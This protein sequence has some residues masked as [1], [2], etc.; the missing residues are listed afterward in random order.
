MEPLVPGS[1]HNPSE[2]DNPSKRLKLDPLPPAPIPRCFRRETP[3]A[4]RKFD[5]VER[6]HAE[7]RWRHMHQRLPE[8]SPMSSRF[9]S[10]PPAEESDSPQEQ[11]PL[12]DTISS[13]PVTEPPRR[14]QLDFSSSI[15]PLSR[16]CNQIVEFEQSDADKFLESQ[17]LVNVDKD[18]GQM[19]PSMAAVGQSGVNDL[20]EDSPSEGGESQP[21]VDEDGEQSD[22][23][24]VAL[25]QSGANHMDEDSQSEGEECQI[26]GEESDGEVEG[27]QSEV[28]GGQ[29]EGED[30]IDQLHADNDGHSDGED[31]IDQLHADNDGQS[32]GEDKIDQF[33]ADNDYKALTSAGQLQ[34][35]RIEDG[36]FQPLRSSNNTRTPP[37]NGERGLIPSPMEV[38]APDHL[39][40]PSVV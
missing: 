7:R 1:L 9:G 32:E 14:A 21:N 2:I 15:L 33:H 36:D 4:S 3:L 31:E 13:E 11:R 23:S 16:Q 19:G 24:R 34:L 38:D 27:S 6:L 22:S 25:W 28:G 20:G 40:S 35:V 30:E 8:Q 29:S 17:A 5:V 37:R 10:E 26:R 39:V 12:S 18:G